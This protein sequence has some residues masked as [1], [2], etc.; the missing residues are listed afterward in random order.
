MDAFIQ[1]RTYFDTMLAKPDKEL[2]SLA[3]RQ[4]YGKSDQNPDGLSDDDIS[5]E[6][7]KLEQQGQLKFRAVE[8]K[9][10]LRQQKT[11]I[12]QER[13]TYTSRTAPKEVDTS[14]AEG[15]Q[16]FRE[17]VRTEVPKVIK[18]GK[19]YGIDMGQAFGADDMNS[20]VERLLLPDSKT[21]QSY[22]QTKLN[23]NNGMIEAA[24]LFKM[25]DEGVLGSIVQ[26]RVN[27]F[28]KKVLGGL[29]QTPPAAGAPASAQGPLTIDY[30]RLRASEQIIDKE[31]SYRK[32]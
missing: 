13:A 2:V 10:G 20:F 5:A 12:E 9:K 8:L 22:L 14:T 26:A 1:E 6:V 3:L 29:E 25:A 15:L 16:E 24:I 27:E 17:T 32:K 4:Q 11:Q 21:G 31:P 19:F 23:G 7:D 30:S 18:E 28:K